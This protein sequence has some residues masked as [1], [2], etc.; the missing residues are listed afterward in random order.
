[1]ALR[2]HGAPHAARLSTR[3]QGT[4]HLTT[5]NRHTDV[6]E[7][8]ASKALLTSFLPRGAQRKRKQTESKRKAKEGKRKHKANGSEAN[9]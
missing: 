4:D 8:L 7:A 3:A 5:S 9:S 1:M 2:R 6:T